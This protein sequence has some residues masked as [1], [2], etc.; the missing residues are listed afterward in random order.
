MGAYISSLI[1]KLFE[2]KKL[3]I[4][5]I[6]L[7]G[8][9][10]SSILGKLHLNEVISTIPTIGFN[11]E[12]VTYKN[13][14]F[15]V[16]DIGGQEKIRPLWRHYYENTDALIFVIDSSDIDRIDIA[17]EELMLTLQDE[18]LANTNLLIFANKQDLPNALSASQII[19]KLQIDKLKTRKWLVQSTCAITGDGLYEGL[20][21]IC[22]QNNINDNTSLINTHATY[23]L[24]NY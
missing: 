1:A 17:R 4:L 13:T 10:K 21:W 9:G 23:N 2:T 5:M 7:D 11:V 12:T 8:A 3:K 16:W 19:E 20:D 6:G 18:K 15:T 14:T 22:N 24:Y